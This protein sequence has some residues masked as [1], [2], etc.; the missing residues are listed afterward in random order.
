[1]RLW[2]EPSLDEGRKI[3]RWDALDAIAQHPD[4]QTRSNQRGGLR[5]Q[6]CGVLQGRVRVRELR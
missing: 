2:A 6:S 4:R 3:D 1:V 5:V